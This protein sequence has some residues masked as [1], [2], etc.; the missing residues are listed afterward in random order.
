MGVQQSKQHV[1]PRRGVS[2]HDKKTEFLNRSRYMTHEAEDSSSSSDGSGES[3]TDRVLTDDEEHFPKE[4]TTPP[5]RKVVNPLSEEVGNRVVKNKK[6]NKIMIA[7]SAEYPGLRR[8]NSMPPTG[9]TNLDTIMQ[10]SFTPKRDPKK[11]KLKPI[12]ASKKNLPIEK[13][14]IN[15]EAPHEDESTEILPSNQQ[16]KPKRSL[17]EE[18][19]KKIEEKIHE[20]LQEKIE[21]LTKKWTPEELKK[22][23][24]RKRTSVVEYI[25]ADLEDYK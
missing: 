19:A 14:S 1:Q 7:K 12:N 17:K 18:K 4:L 9:Q 21:P 3:E 16:T 23:V 20:R 22:M 25:K 10:L 11:T 6:T 5:A 15:V 24:G 13:V 2:L 8:S